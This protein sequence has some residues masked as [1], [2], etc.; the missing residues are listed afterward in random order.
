MWH[1]VD[2]LNA[3][4]SQNKVMVFYLTK[5]SGW[6][7]VNTCGLSSF[8]CPHLWM[9][10]SL[11]HLGQFFS[12]FLWNLLLEGTE[13]LYKWSRSFNAMPMYG[14]KF[15]TLKN[16]LFQNQESFKAEFFSSPELKAWGWAI[17]VTCRP[18]VC[19]HLWMT[20]PLKPLGQFSSNFMWS[21]LL[22]V[23]WKFVQMVM[24]H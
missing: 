22:K 20:S 12:N 23:D 1:R 7:I 15:W 8:V 19:P 21:F 17:V 18:S 9:T 11:K 6:A 5:G 16:L 14:K 24:A 2:R 10:Y 4:D 13:N 3:F